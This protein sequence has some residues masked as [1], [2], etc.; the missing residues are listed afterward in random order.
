VP[1]PDLRAPSSVVLLDV[2][3]LS[4]RA[5]TGDYPQV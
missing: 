5:P 1:I 2:A 4:W 3:P